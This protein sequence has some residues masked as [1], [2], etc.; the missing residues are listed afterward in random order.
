MGKKKIESYVKTKTVYVTSQ[1]EPTPENA[2]RAINLAFG[3]GKG[4]VVFAT[5]KILVS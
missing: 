4:T 5:K 1:E 3:G 2:K